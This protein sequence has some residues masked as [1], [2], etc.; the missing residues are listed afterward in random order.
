[1]QSMAYRSSLIA[2]ITGYLYASCSS[3]IIPSLQVS[4]RDL[5]ERVVSTSNASRTF[6]YVIVGGGTAGLTIANRLSEDP[7]VHVAVIE[8]GTFYEI[9]S[10]NTSEIPADDP[11]Y[12][13]KDPK[14]TGPVDWGFTTTPQA[15]LLIPRQSL[16]TTMANSPT[17][18]KQSDSALCARKDGMENRWLFCFHALI[19]I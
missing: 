17:G 12:N 4:S 19:L 11:A 16:A 18:H 6:D 1:M 15:V 13:G 10:G 9:A 7:S 3:S 2:L 5:L 14:D 8:A